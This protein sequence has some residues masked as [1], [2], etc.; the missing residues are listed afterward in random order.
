MTGLRNALRLESEDREHRVADELEHLPAPRAP[1]CSQRSEN[2]VEEVDDHRT[3]RCV[4]DRGEA[5]DV[6][7]PARRACTAAPG[8]PAA[9]TPTVRRF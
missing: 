7:I 5:A 3:G 6:G 2:I 4:G 1:R 8:N 9:P